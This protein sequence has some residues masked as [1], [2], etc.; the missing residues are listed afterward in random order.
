MAKEFSRTSRLGEQLQRELAKTIQFEM[1][2]PRLGMVTLNQVTVSKDLGYADVHFTVMAAQGDSDEHIQAQTEAI[3]NDAAGYLRSKMA[4]IVTARTTPALRFHYDKS[5]EQ[6]H[7]LT[8]L[9]DEARAKDKAHSSD[10]P[11]GDDEQ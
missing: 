7:F 6:G 5:L 8:G 3:L 1:K 10:K 9:I 11:V 4:K 2:D